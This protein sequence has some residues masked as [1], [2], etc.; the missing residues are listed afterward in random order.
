MS[1]SNR[2]GSLIRDLLSQIDE[3]N[4]GK[5]ED[6]DEGEDISD[7]ELLNGFMDGY[8]KEDEEDE[9]IIKKSK[10]SFFQL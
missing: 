7:S 9:G 1:A 5:S 4:F 8:N 10:I 6:L 2:E 3:K